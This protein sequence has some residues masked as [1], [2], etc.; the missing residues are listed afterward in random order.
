MSS[1]LRKYDPA[2]LDPEQYAFYAHYLPD[3]PRGKRGRSGGIPL[4]DADGQLVGPSAA[5]LLNPAFGQDYI[6]LGL[7]VRTKT[8]L[9]PRSQEIII[10]VV[11]QRLQNAFERYAHEAAARAIG[12]SDDEIAALSN[13]DPITFADPEEQ[14]CYQLTH[15]MMAT[16]GLG[17]DA[18]AHAVEVLG[19]KGLF[20]VT[21][22]IG[23]YWTAALQ[24]SV[25]GITPP[26]S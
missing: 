25:F 8:G 17:D 24:M 7:S 11:G 3:S 5:W 22:I 1:R 23:W 6:P 2:D 14:A 21:A 10:L 9:S 19:E 12:M 18:Y 4:L 15:T 13:G 26:Q 20:G 16:G